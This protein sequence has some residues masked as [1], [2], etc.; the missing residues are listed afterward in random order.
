MVQK[1]MG[2]FIAE[3]IHDGSGKQCKSARIC[4]KLVGCSAPNPDY[5]RERCG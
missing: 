1:A 4:K 5:Q 3:I 2:Y